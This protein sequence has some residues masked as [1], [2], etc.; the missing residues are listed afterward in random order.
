MSGDPKPPVPERAWPPLI[1]AETAPQWVRR[2]DFFL[3]LLMWIL[4]AIMLETE[5]ELFFGSFLERMGLGDFDTEANWGIFFE[6][7]RPYLTVSLV[8]ASTLAFASILTL[9]RRRRT[10]SQEPPAPLTIAEHAALVGMEES[11]LRA[12]REMRNCVVHID[13]ATGRH[14]VEPR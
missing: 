9:L 5:F 4:F 1:V 13:N 14:W 6:R 8:L 10:L 2:R 11:D 12:A 3:T 7:L